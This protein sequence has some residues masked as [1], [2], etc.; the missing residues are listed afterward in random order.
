MSMRTGKET[1]ENCVERQRSGLMISKR[2]KIVE[3]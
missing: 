3:S 2:P 1:T